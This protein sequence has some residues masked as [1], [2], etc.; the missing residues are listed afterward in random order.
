M[1][2]HLA[3]ETRIEIVCDALQ[4]DTVPTFAIDETEPLPDDLLAWVRQH[5]Q[6]LDWIMEGDVTCMIRAM[7]RQRATR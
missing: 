3:I 5:R 2:D 6:S 4:L 1:I 7:A